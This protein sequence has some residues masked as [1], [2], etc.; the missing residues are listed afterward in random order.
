MLTGTRD[1][2]I[3][4]SAWGNLTDTYSTFKAA[5]V[6][7]HR[8][9][10]TVVV[11]TPSPS[12]SPSATP[13]PSPSGTPSPS[14]TPSPSA[15]PAPATATP[16][17]SP[18]PTAAPAPPTPTPAAASN[19]T[20][21]TPDAAM[22]AGVTG[23]T[24]T[25]VVKS[26]VTEQSTTISTSFDTESKCK[27]W[28]HSFN[29]NKERKGLLDTLN[30]G[31]S[32]KDK[33]DDSMITVGNAD[34]K[35]ARK[36]TRRLLA[37]TGAFGVVVRDQIT[38]GGTTGS[39][40]ASALFTA[41]KTAVTAGQVTVNGAKASGIADPVVKVYAPGTF[42]YTP[43]VAAAAAVQAAPAALSI[44][45]ESTQA[46]CEAYMASLPS[47][48]LDAED[49]LYVAVNALRGPV[50][51]SQ[52]AIAGISCTGSGVLVAASFG[53]GGAYATGKA[54]ADAV[55]ATV[56]ARTLKLGPYT[57][58]AST[59]SAAASIAM[60]LGAILPLVSG[61]LASL[62]GLARFQL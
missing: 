47:G 16:T 17:P 31:R 19:S 18:S 12:P 11:P 59:P 30:N 10:V 14:P 24:S 53:G 32:D 28:K 27:D 22:T 15:T 58:T 35:N 42:T 61:L 62:L 41:L 3:F 26:N 5:Y 43:P 50:S 6:F 57:A 21:A 4:Y 51:R 39:V 23:P 49:A 34:C 40:G 46:Q 36:A 8:L 13:S 44:R 38:A 33:F 37:T 56:A 20:S 2:P 45:F 29:P 7:A 60:G 54:L 25:V 48:L 1:Y 52:V 55:Q 9:N